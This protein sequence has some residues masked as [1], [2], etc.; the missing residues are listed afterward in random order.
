MP[1]QQRMV[2]TAEGP[3][4]ATPVEVEEARESFNSYRLADGNT[5]KLKTVVLDVVKLVG[6][7]DEQGNPV[8]LVQHKVLMTVVP[9][10]SA[11]SGERT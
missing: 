7:Q 1:P 5:I 4:E 11:S 10:S 3:K 2:T 6:Q 9:G 8:Y